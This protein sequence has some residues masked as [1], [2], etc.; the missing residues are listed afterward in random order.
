MTYRC[1]APLDFA[2]IAAPGSRLDPHA[3]QLGIPC[4]GGILLAHAE[5]TER[6]TGWSVANLAVN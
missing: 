6:P 2:T 1:Q 3:G 4:G 5:P